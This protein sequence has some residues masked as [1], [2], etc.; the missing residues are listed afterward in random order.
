MTRQLAPCGTQAAYTRH[1]RHG[2]QACAACR[3]ACRDR[4]RQQRA[5]VAG[6]KAGEKAS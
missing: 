2:E 4:A 1:L 6:R 3:K 5:A